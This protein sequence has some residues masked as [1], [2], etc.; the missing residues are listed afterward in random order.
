MTAHQFHRLADAA[1]ELGV[2]VPK[3]L[4]VQKSKM[5]NK[6][7][8]KVT[9]DGYN[10]RKLLQIAYKTNETAFTLSQKMIFMKN[11]GFT[12]CHREN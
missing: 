11:E 2:E 9:R 4:I 3:F 6:K 8:V 12:S 5:S 1:C 7:A 10:E